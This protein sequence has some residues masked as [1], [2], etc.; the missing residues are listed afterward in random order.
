MN[1]IRI[2]M[3]SPSQRQDSIGFFGPLVSFCKS[4]NGWQWQFVWIQYKYRATHKWN[5]CFA[6]ISN[7]FTRLMFIIISGI[8]KERK[9]ILIQ[10]CGFTLLFKIAWYSGKNSFYLI[11]KLCPLQCNAMVEARDEH[12]LNGLWKSI[13]FIIIVIHIN[14]IKQWYW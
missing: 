9:N 8:P 1:P 3:A 4:T 6:R 14:S 10:W 13:D 11:H 7:T 12:S 2:Q 5:K